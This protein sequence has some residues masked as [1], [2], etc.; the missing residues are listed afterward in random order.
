M[1]SGTGS[2]QLEIP[3]VFWTLILIKEIKRVSS[4]VGA[5]PAS[6]WDISP[7]W[8][9]SESG[10][11]LQHCAHGT[12]CRIPL[13]SAPR[14]PDGGVNR[15]GHIS[16]HYH[17]ISRTKRTE[18]RFRKEGSCAGGV[19]MMLQAPTSCGVQQRCLP[20]L[21]TFRS[22]DVTS[23]RYVRRMQSLRTTSRAHVTV[24]C[25]LNNSTVVQGGARHQTSYS[26]SLR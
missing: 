26:P 15:P 12:Q 1:L 3:L 23:C 5:C 4:Y 21:C 13:V 6:L 7:V 2:E 16:R 24:V 8:C 9:L 10:A 17:T 22:T 20:S 19:A 18:L 14:I 25:S 11:H